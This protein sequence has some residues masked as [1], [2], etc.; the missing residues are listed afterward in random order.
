MFQI[1]FEQH[2]IAIIVMSPTGDVLYFFDLVSSTCCNES[3]QDTP[4]W[5]QFFKSTEDINICS[6]VL[7]ASGI[8]TSSNHLINFL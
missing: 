2:I 8:D 4:S 7:D 6:K 1:V 3:W 5:E